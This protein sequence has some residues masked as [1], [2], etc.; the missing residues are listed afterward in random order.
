MTT[1]LTGVVLGL[2]AALVL[3]TSSGCTTVAKQAFHEF[4]GAKADVSFVRD[5]GDRALAVYR[6]VEF[7]SARS[8]VGLVCPPKVLQ[9]WDQHAGE[10][11]AELAEY[12]PGGPPTL[13]IESEI[14]FFKEKGLLGHAECLARVRMRDSGTVKADLIVQALSKSFRA[15]DES[16]LTRAAVQAIGKFL[17]NQKKAEENDEEEEDD[18]RER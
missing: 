11:Q 12:F 3:S 1:R 6:S 4:R 5:I 18:D 15:G 17:K 13:R 9:A 8:D 2:L 14:W 16:A 7:E 10:E